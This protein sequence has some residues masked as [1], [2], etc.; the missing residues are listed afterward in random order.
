MRRRGWQLLLAFGL[1]AGLAA[2][3]CGDSSKEGLNPKVESPN[4]PQP[5]SKAASK[6]PMPE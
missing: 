3:G 1:L 5:K 2:A 6:A 4:A